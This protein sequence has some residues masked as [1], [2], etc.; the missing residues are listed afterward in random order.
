[1]DSLWVNCCVFLDRL[2]GLPL[3]RAMARLEG[4]VGLRAQ[5][6]YSTLARLSPNRCLAGGPTLTVV[7]R[8]GPAAAPEPFN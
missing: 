6:H 1:M 4:P 7:Q 8:C 2:A 5:G 3:R